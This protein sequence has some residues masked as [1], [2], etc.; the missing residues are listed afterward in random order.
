M[1]LE[2]LDE[3][4]TPAMSTVCCGWHLVLSNTFFPPTIHTTLQVLAAMLNLMRVLIRK[5]GARLNSDDDHTRYVVVH[6]IY[7]PLKSRLCSNTQHS[8]EPVLPYFLTTTTILIV[9]WRSSVASFTLFDSSQTTGKFTSLIDKRER[10]TG[11]IHN[12]IL[13]LPQSSIL[14]RVVH[15][16]CFIS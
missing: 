6:S 7:I 10:R 4:E 8:R 5:T 13:L 14:I 12:I 15:V 9:D 16:L 3:K 11:V 1:E 2:T